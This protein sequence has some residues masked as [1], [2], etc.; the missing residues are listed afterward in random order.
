MFLSNFIVKAQRKAPAQ[1]LF[2]LQEFEKFSMRGLYRPPSPPCP[3]RPSQH[4]WLS[5]FAL[6]RTLRNVS[7]LTFLDPP[8]E[9][10]TFLIGLSEYRL[11]KR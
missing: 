3:L 5:V 4:A 11:Q 10:T 6:S 9:A 1:M 7:P 2:S 8:V